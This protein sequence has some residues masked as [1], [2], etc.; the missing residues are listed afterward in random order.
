MELPACYLHVG[1]L[2]T[3]TSSL[4]HTLAASRE[5]LL[6]R[7]I[8]YFPGAVNH[9]HLLIPLIRQGPDH[10]PHAECL[11]RNFD[12]EMARNE[13][14]KVV[15][16]GEALSQLAPPEV[17]VLHD[18]LGRRFSRIRIIIYVRD[19]YGYA[20]SAAQE[21][22]KRGVATFSTLREQPPAPRYRFLI[23]KYRRAFG[24]ENTDIRR[25]H[26]EAWARGNIYADFCEAI[27]ES[28]D[29]AGRLKIV[30]GNRSLSGPAVQ[31]LEAINRKFPA[32]SDGVMSSQ[33]RAINQACEKQKGAPF[34]LDDESLTKLGRRI[35]DDVAWLKTA[36]AGQIDFT[37][38]R[39]PPPPSG[40]AKLEPDE[41]ERQV[42]IL[43]A[44]LPQVDGELNP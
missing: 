41:L 25:F 43:A 5:V 1:M 15:F 27:G 18:F 44:D 4:Q 38:S 16:S 17:K 9:S 10:E 13:C 22:I 28:P 32:T 7:G 8:N 19:P 11:R 35:G 23:E 21:R 29:L 34:Q 36:T 42:E 2:K 6:A 24:A 12:A 31:I 3:A 33:R 14:S 30:E 20:S 39:P 37:A 26:L 40:L